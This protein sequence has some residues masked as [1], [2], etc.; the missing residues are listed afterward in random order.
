MLSQG[1]G[2]ADLTA[3]AHTGTYTSPPITL[4]STAG[5]TNAVCSA[6]PY[7]LRACIT[8]ALRCNCR[9]QRGHH[10]CATTLQLC[11][12]QW[13]LHMKPAAF[14]LSGS[15]SCPPL[16]A[17]RKSSSVPT[18]SFTPAHT[19]KLKHSVLRTAGRHREA[20][21][22]QLYILPCTKSLQYAVEM[23]T[24]PYLPCSDGM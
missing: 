10:S 5:T 21:D 17:L 24:C 9:M 20:C 22:V 4:L 3:E 23:P 13:G 15:G 11:A 7:H 1:T 12:D 6:S 19:D 14:L 18:D 16:E 8:S 2:R